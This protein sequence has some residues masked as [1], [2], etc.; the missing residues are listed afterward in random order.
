MEGLSSSYILPQNISS[1]I[2]KIKA[3]GGDKVRFIIMYGSY[4]N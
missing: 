2:K 3:I 4:H 1:V